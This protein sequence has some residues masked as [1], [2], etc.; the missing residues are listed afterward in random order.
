[1]TQVEGFDIWHI[2]WEKV[3]SFGGKEL[4]KTAMILCILED[5]RLE[6]WV[7]T[8]KTKLINQL[9]VYRGHILLLLSLQQVKQV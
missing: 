3:D 9:W 4:S 1:V 5:V 8:Q 6:F 2:L 7:G